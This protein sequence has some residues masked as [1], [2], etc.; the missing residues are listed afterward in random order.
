MGLTDL[1]EVRA[2]NLDPENHHFLMLSQK[3]KRTVFYTVVSAC[4]GMLTYTSLMEQFYK[5]HVPFGSGIAYFDEENELGELLVYTVP[6]AVDGSTTTKSELLV[7]Q[8]SID[9]MMRLAL[10]AKSTV[11]VLSVVHKDTWFPQS[12]S[13]TPQFLPK[14]YPPAFVAGFESPEEDQDEEP[15]SSPT[16][17]RTNQPP[18][19][20]DRRIRQTEPFSWT[21]DR[22]P[23]WDW[24]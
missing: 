23:D 3:N 21:H 7:S 8:G 19:R 18:L 2:K 13:S 15:Q 22:Q 24:L 12:R 10:K 9:T 5:T 1:N 6:A 20:K 17:V 16:P 14:S 11:V 4:D